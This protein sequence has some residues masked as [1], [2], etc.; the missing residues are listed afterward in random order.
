MTDVFTKQS[1][2]TDLALRIIHAGARKSD[3]IGTPVSIAVVDEGGLL[4]GFLRMD[5]AS[6]PGIQVAQD[7]AFTAAGLGMATDEWFDFIQTVPSLAA[8]APTGIERNVIF[9]GGL[10][11]SVGDRVVGGIGVAG[12]APSQDL[13]IAQAALEAIGDSSGVTGASGG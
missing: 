9:P 11:I 8:G 6:A 4:K 2:S 12:G 1:I 10:P 5:N 3:E 7:K 13:E